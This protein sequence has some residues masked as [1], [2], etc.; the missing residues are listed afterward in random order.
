M[1]VEIDYKTCG[2]CLGCATICPESLFY[3]ED[4]VLKIKDGCIDC[5]SCIECCPVKAIS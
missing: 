2:F 5:G 3:I 4:D 1:P